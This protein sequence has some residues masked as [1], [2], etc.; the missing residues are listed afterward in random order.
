M[1]EATASGRGLVDISLQPWAEFERFQAR[2]LFADPSLAYCGFLAGNTRGLH[3]PFAS[4]TT[5]RGVC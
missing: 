4:H 3:S 5:Q 2:L 1:A